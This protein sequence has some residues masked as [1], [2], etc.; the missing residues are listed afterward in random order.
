MRFYT[1]IDATTAE[2][3]FAT[4]VNAV[5]KTATATIATLQRNAPVILSTHTASNNGYFIDAPATGTSQVNNLFVGIVDSFPDT[6]TGQTGTW[7]GEDAGQVQIYG[8]RSG[9]IYLAAS[10]GV[11]VGDL[12]IPDS[13]YGRGHLTTSGSPSTHAASTGTAANATVPAI[14]GLCVAVAA[15]AS[16]TA[17]QTSAAGVF[18]RG[19]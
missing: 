17:T 4:Y 15:V 10:V 8:Y 19:M 9:L 3:V 12:L 16:A 18:L 13:V 14:A 6:S 11:A 1:G 7:Q 5:T 2:K